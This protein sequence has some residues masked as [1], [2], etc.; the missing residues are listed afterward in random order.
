M[1]NLCLKTL[2]EYSRVLDRIYT[3]DIGQSYQSDFGLWIT[4][5]Y[6]GLSEH[7]I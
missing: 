6:S 3:N 5:L 2:T 4:L 7:G 1:N